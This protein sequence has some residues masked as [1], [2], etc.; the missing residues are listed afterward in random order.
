[1]TMSAKKDEIASASELSRTGDVANRGAANDAVPFTTSGSRNLWLIGA[2]MS[3]GLVIL[4]GILQ[5]SL[6]NRWGV[7]ENVKEIGGRLSTIPLQLGVWQADKNQEIDELSLKLLECEGYILRT[8]VHQSTGEKVNVAVFFGPK[9]PI[10]VHT[11]E[12]C[13]SSKNVVPTSE[14]VAKSNDYDGM[15]N[16][17]WRLGFVTPGIERDKL[18][19]AYAWSDG[20]AWTAAVNPRF[21]RTD[22]L[23][24][25][26]TAT[27]VIGNKQDTTD[28]FFRAF[29]PE[30]RKVMRTGA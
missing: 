27:P 20:G 6:S 24:K 16:E 29:L 10:A 7:S 30:L 3:I 21:W 4:G 25:I 18:N 19:V 15:N 9:G 8:Y 28:E 2:A 13:Y 23:Y 17:I 5:G 14:R 26:Q 22:Y 12:V 1:M 11:P